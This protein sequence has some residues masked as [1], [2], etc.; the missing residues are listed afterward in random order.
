MVRS[1][2]RRVESAP[3]EYA[4]PLTRDAWRDHAAELADGPTPKRRAVRLLSTTPV[5][6][7]PEHHDV[8]SHLLYAGPYLHRLADGSLLEEQYV[9]DLDGREHAITDPACPWQRCDCG[10]RHTSGPAL[11]ARYQHRY[12]HSC[13]AVPCGGQDG[14]LWDYHQE[15]AEDARMGRPRTPYR[16][17]P[18]AALML[19]YD[20]A[21]LCEI[22][23]RLQH[24]V[25][26]S[27]H[28][29]SDY[30]YR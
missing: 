25:H 20:P 1:L 12:D 17:E 3:A 27:G 15:A 19:H 21:E 7:L 9:V 18:A 5:Y 4:G 10:H 6:E 30:R 24:P 22:S 29:A 2:H 26:R 14:G 11:L 13:D 23:D 28:R 8:P 16:Q